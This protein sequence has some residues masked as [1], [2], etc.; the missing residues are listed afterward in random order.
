MKPKLGGLP[1][2]L[3]MTIKERKVLSQKGSYD[4]NVGAVQGKPSV[5]KGERRGPQ[6]MFSPATATGCSQ[7]LRARKPR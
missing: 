1:V 7:G 2:H 5:C 6:D 4:K 3:L